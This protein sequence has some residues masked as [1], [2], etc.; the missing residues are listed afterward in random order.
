MAELD[1]EQNQSQTNND[2]Q[3]E[4]QFDAA[5]P[6][7]KLGFLRHRRQGRVRLKKRI[8]PLT[9]DG[10]SEVCFTAAELGGKADKVGHIE[11][12]GIARSADAFLLID[13]VVVERQ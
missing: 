10:W 2:V 5:A 12:G 4:P 11:V 13:D 9:R 6:F 7:G 1:G 3:K 8:E